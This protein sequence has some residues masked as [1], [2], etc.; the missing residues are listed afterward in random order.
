[1][2][3]KNALKIAVLYGV[4]SAV[5]I[6]FSDKWLLALVQDPE[7]LTELQTYKGWAF[8]ALSALLIFI[9][10]Y[11]AFSQ[12]DLLY[13]SDPLTKLLRHFRF[14][15]N[16]EELLE[17]QQRETG[18]ILVMEVDIDGFK[19]VNTQLG[20]TRADQF[21]QLFSRSLQENY[22]ADTLIARTGIDRFLIAKRQSRIS[23]DI[24]DEEIDEVQKIIAQVSAKFGL[25]CT[26]CIGL[27]LYPRDGEKV[28]NLLAAA[29]TALNHA[30]LAGP[31][32]ARVHN[33]ELSE[34]QS[35]RQQMLS[36]LQIALEEDRLS[37]VYQPQFFAET[38]QISGCE[39]LVRWNDPV[40]GYVAPDI[41]IILAEQ[42]GLINR[43]T[44]TVLRKT[45]AEL[46]EAG[47][48]QG[49]LSRVSVNLSA[50]EF[51]NPLMME[52]LMAQ[53]SDSPGFAERLQFEVT[54]TAA[55]HDL[56]NSV[57]LISSFRREGIRFS[58][59]DF[60]TGYSSLAILKDLPVHELK[61]DRGF[62]NE[63]LD[64]PKAAAIVES[65]ILMASS[66]DASIVAE[67]VETEEQLQRLQTYGCDEVQGFLL[68]KPMKIA[69]LK[70][71]VQQQ[72]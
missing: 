46:T 49:T 52:R 72:G 29:T 70:N 66:F 68:A 56:Q 65:V 60:G 62:I 59:D 41:F 69:E 16:L 11:R 25:N 42:Y 3:V 67:G 19:H 26:V 45:Y 32:T 17:E 37:L 63:L 8:V 61:I 54:E 71:F 53:I 35:K 14:Q 57:E 28:K 51:S 64:Q 27:S 9:L 1:M 55:L 34:Q 43:I 4:L 50:L 5:W 2:S 18:H 12:L 58:I 21:L 6:L 23:N 31:G 13:Q 44:E 40:L 48:L 7:R 15:L 47:L 39:V 20:Y 30:R 22:T 10:A 38:R 24:I 36:R 33:A